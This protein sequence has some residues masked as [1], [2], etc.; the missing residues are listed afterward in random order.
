MGLSRNLCL[1]HIAS[2][3]QC[4]RLDNLAYLYINGQACRVSSGHGFKLCGLIHWGALLSLAGVEV[5]QQCTG[6]RHAQQGRCPWVIHQ[7]QQ[8]LQRVGSL[9]QAHAQAQDD[10]G[11][12][13]AFQRLC[14]GFPM[15]LCL[16]AS[17]D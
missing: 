17:L 4:D 5:G 3:Q 16:R 11:S 8:P 14:G 6:A 2:G 12:L 10:Y 15:R 13:R 9:R 1:G 7:R